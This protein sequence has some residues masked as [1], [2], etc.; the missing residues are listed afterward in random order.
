MKFRVFYFYPPF[1]GE[2]SSMIVPEDQVEYHDGHFTKTIR[3]YEAKNWSVEEIKPKEK[4]NEKR[5]IH[6][7]TG[8]LV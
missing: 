8:Q 4:H 6:P 2:P 7:Q 1:D 3:R 5:E